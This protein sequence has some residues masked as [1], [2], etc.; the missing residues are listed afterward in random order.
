MASTGNVFPGTGENNTGT[1]AT[2]WT[3]PGNIV[4]DNTTD[5]SCNAAA[6]SQYLV[7][8]NFNFASIPDG[9]LIQGI[10]VRIEASES[11]TGSETLNARLQ[12]DAGALV[13]NTKTASINGTGKT[14]YTYG[15]TNDAWAAGLTAAKVKNANFGVRFWFTTAHNIAVDYVT[16]AV[17]YLA[18]HTGT[19]SVSESG[20]DTL[21]SSGHVYVRGAL[22]GS[23]S[24]SDSLSASGTVQDPQASG[25]LAVT[26]SGGDSFAGT[27]NVLIRGAMNATESADSVAVSGKVLVTGAASAVES[28]SD[29]LSATGGV[30]V[31]GALAAS[32]SGSDTASA[33]GTVAIRGTFAALEQGGDIFLGSG[34]QVTMGALNATEGA[35]DSFA[36]SGA[37]PIRGTVA[38]SE[39]ADTLAAV[40]MVAWPAIEGMLQASESGNDGITVSGRILIIGALAATETGQDGFSGTSGSAVRF[41]LA[42]ITQSRP[43]VGS[44]R[45]FSIPLVPQR[46][47][48]GQ[49]GRPAIIQQPGA[50]PNNGR[51]R[52]YP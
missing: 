48:E 18:P 44:R 45:Y 6:T 28:G 25:T 39:A 5:A 34:S 42:G 32:E 26:E 24:G 17:E 11:S 43:I 30:Q 50:R 31:R 2:A 1:G 3:N 47:I 10:T 23:E 16:L 40:G 52:T 37:V 8:R 14:V 33:A 13:G 7:A 41:P 4:S 22:S 51:K 27:G 19:L 29:T 46:P 15:A 12:D 9:S 36:G 21:A 49:L 35:T 20:A 38:I